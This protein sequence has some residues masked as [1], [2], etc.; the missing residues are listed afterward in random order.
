MSLVN[1]YE[2]PLSALENKVFFLFWPYLAH[3]WPTSGHSEDES[4]TFSQTSHLRLE[5]NLIDSICTQT[6]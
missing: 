3:I 2:I 6:M 1:H 5:I 4:L